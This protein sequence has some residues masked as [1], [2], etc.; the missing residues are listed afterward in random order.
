MGM[1]GN[2]LMGK[3]DHK[4]ADRLFILAYLLSLVGLAGAIVYASGTAGGLRA[5]FP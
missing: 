3:L 2:K 1:G 5:M 4:T